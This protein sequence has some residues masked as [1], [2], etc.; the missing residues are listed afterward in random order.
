[1]GLPSI[2]K[3]VCLSVCHVT[4][5]IHTQKVPQ[6]GEFEMA[7]NKNFPQVIPVIEVR[8]LNEAKK[9]SFKIHRSMNLQWLLL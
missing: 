3:G 4:S 9:G 1:M 6:R 8:A 2:N 7:S 5:V